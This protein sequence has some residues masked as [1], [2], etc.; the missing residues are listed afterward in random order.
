MSPAGEA[1][2]CQSLRRYLLEE[3]QWPAAAIRVKPFWAPGK[4][5]LH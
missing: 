4:I 1:L 2:T 5:G 3:K